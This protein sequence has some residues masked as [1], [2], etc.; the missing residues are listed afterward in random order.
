MKIENI[1]MPAPA[2]P[3]VSTNH[4]A[5]KAYQDAYRDAYGV[6]PTVEQKGRWFAPQYHPY[7]VDAK[8]LRELTTMLKRRA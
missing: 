2:K 7:Q 1:P 8:R 5:V 6:T 3:K 4:K